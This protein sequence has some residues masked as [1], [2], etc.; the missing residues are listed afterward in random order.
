MCFFTTGMTKH[1]PCLQQQK[2][3]DFDKTK[4]HSRYIIPPTLNKS[5]HSYIE[6][7]M[8][9]LIRAFYLLFLMEKPHIPPVNFSPTVFLLNQAMD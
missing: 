3:A 5:D 2:Q 1:I 7:A 6:S 8:K 4:K 9:T